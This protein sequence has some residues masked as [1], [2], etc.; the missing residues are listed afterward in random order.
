ML[1]L[2]RFLIILKLILFN[3][4]KKRATL[5]GSRIIGGLSD[6]TAPTVQS[7]TVENIAPT[8]VVVVFDEVITGT[9]LGLTI[10]GTT[11]TGSPASIS[12]SGTSTLTLTL[13][14]AVAEG[15]S[16]TLAYNSG[17]G[18]IADVANPPNDLVT[19]G[20][21]AIT[22][23][24]LDGLAYLTIPD[25]PTF[26]ATTT[27]NPTDTFITTADLGGNTDIILG[28][29]N[30]TPSIW[31]Q[32]LVGTEGT[33]IR[34]KGVGGVDDVEATHIGSVGLAAASNQF[35]TCEWIELYDL[36]GTYGQGFKFDQD[37]EH[38]LFQNIKQNGF[39][40]SVGYAGFLTKTDD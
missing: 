23:N 36:Y 5:V 9:N 20:A 34:F 37:S 3:E 7:M 14:V 38:I 1:I 18:D 21:T 32:G 11:S 4:M 40:H 19:F 29:G 13:A 2:N 12:G 35:N 17:S 28:A 39:S 33:P 27:I 16:P 8:K 15:E 25:A 24:V 22:N 26:G 31:Y 10:A 30:H 6:T